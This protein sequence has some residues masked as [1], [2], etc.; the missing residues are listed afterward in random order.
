[1]GLS[2]VKPACTGCLPSGKTLPLVPDLL[3]S[4]NGAQVEQSED[5]AIWDILSGQWG[6]LGSNL[7]VR[8]TDPPASANSASDT[9]QKGRRLGRGS[10]KSWGSSFLGTFDSFD[11]LWV[12]DIHPPGADPM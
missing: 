3:W 7:L 12:C 8:T 5:L 9:G 10:V 11:Y 2:G 6:F 1:V 4:F